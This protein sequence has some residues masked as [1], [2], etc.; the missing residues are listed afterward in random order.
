MSTQAV[1]NREYYQFVNS[2]ETR[3]AR[4]NASAMANL[5][6][7]WDANGNHIGEGWAPTWGDSLWALGPVGTYYGSRAGIMSAVNG[8]P[9]GVNLGFKGYLKA[10]TTWGGFKHIEWVDQQVFRLQG[11]MNQ[12]TSNVPAKVFQGSDPNLYSLKNLYNELRVANAAKAEQLINQ[13]PNGWQKLQELLKANNFEGE[14]VKLQNGSGAYR[15]AY[16]GALNEFKAAQQTLR[17]GQALPS[18]SFDRLSRTGAIADLRASRLNKA[19]KRLFW[20]KWLGQSKVGQAYHGAKAWFASAKTGTGALGKTLRGASRWGG[21]ALGVGAIALE[22]GLVGMETY[23]AVSA[24]PEG[25]KW[26]DGSR[27]FL[28]SGSKAAVKCGAAWA[29]MK[30]GAA[31]GSSIG[32]AIGTVIP[33]IGNA[34]GA[35]VGGFLGGL[36]GGIVGYV[37]AEKAIDNEVIPGAKWMNKSVPEERMAEQKR[38]QDKIINKA[39][40]EKDVNTVGQYVSQFF[41]VDEQT[42]ET[43]MDQNGEPQIMK[44]SDDKNQ[45]AAFEKRVRG[46]MNF[47]M[48][49]SAKQEEAERI[50][51]EYEQELEARRQA[52]EQ[53]R[54]MLAQQQAYQATTGNF[55]SLTSGASSQYTA[56]EGYFGASEAGYKRYQNSLNANSWTNPA[57][58]ANLGYMYNSGAMNNTIDGNFYNPYMMP[59]F[60]Y[61]G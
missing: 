5:S 53:Q 17:S 25:Q 22:V 6:F 12:Y 21:K 32:G 56:P 45:Q 28:K 54:A 55:G 20:N 40:N 11:L 4:E 1:H 9:N 19:P 51:Q 59:Q 3:Q 47:V 13:Y 50:R 10:N 49:E 16:Q 60:D 44:V 36:I 37:G 30:V 33:V 48:T 42:G 18:G 29:G 35:A 8:A 23:S 31:V 39:I 15:N 52:Q 34:F 58:Q 41:V 38:E 7:G 57:F 14:I 26:R 46:L 61:V 27:Q 43:V 24:A 2:I